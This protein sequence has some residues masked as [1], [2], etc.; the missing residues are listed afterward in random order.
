[1]ACLAAAILPLSPAQAQPDYPNRPITLINPYAAGGP[2][3]M[4]ARTLAAQLKNRLGQTVVVESKA[5]G[6]ATIGTGY[7]ARAKPDGYTLLMAT[8]PGNVVGPLI[9]RLPYNGISDF[10]F[11]GM[12]G[13][14]PIMLVAGA[15]QGINNIQDLLDRARKSPGSLDYASAGTGGP[16]HLA[17]ELLRRRTKI[18]ITHVPYRGAA[19]AVQDVIGG[20]VELGMLSLAPTLPFIKD[21]R[22][23]A[24]AYTGARRSPLLPDVPTMAEAGINWSEVSTWYI[25]A[26]PHGT[27]AAVIKKLSEAVTAINADPEHQKFLAEQDASVIQM[28]PAELTSYVKKDKETM[29]DLLGSLDML[30]K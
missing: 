7:V 20:Q 16:T 2:A 23:K 6:A 22:L 4:L 5:G 1:M 24:I 13:N 15:N 29:L 18:D 30:A 14:Q 3:D 27:P 9:Q 26:A 8:S 10:E 12:V 19:P 21:G 17:G 25:L 11:I 28:S